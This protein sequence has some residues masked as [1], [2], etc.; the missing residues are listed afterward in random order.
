MSEKRKVPL[1]PILLSRARAMRHDPAPAETK[2]WAFLRDRQLGGYKFRRQVPLG[3]FIADFY[4]HQVDLVVELD[5]ESHLDRPQSDAVRTEILSRD[6]HRVIRFWNTDVFENFHG[7]LEALYEECER[8]AASEPPHPDPL[9]EREGVRRA[10]EVLRSSGVVAFPTETVYGLGADATNPRAVERVFRIKG[11]PSTNPLIV[12]VADENV[13]KR[14]ARSWPLAASRLVARFWPGPLTLV[15]PKHESIVP[16]VTAGLDTVGLRAPNH[17]L[18]LELLGAF[19]GPLAG[20]SANRSSHL[21]PT[22]A[23]HV[24]DE[25]G[26]EVDLILDGGPCSVG[27]ESTV[28]DLS[29]D[30]PAILRPGA[31][32]REQIEEVIGARVEFKQLVTEVTSPA[33][34]PGQQARHYAPRT[35][36]F[37]IAPSQIA[38][39]DLTNAAVLDLTLDPESYA[40]N[41]YARLRMLDRQDL[42]SIYIVMPPDA[43]QWAAVRDRIFR[44]TRPL[45]DAPSDLTRPS[46]ES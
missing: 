23:Q 41:F 1:N 32:R 5:G 29:R 40:R 22:A 24:R 12:H 11:R 21:S 45:S 17:P 35:P 30:V 20:P 28:L 15:L 25:L 42:K 13:A 8:I 9:P 2:L 4:C 3:G 39:L 44:A 31:I 14:Y 16:Q 46:G 6:G 34:A 18:A 7:V 36:A 26:D 10:V 38:M 19:D 27:I 33:V 37:R 43:P